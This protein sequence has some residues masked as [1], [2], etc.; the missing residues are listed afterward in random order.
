MS[1]PAKR[2]FFDEAGLYEYAVGALS[3]KMRTVA[4]LKRLLRRRADEELLVDVVI[5]RLKEQKYL[6][7]HKYAAAYSAYRQ[8]NE[9]FGKRRVITDLKTKGVHSEVIEKVVGEAYSGVNEEKLA[10]E[11]LARKRLR[12]PTNERET[13]RV[14]RA[15]LRAGFSSSIIFKI[16]KK[17]QVPDETLG[18]LEAEEEPLQQE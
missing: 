3:R 2:K 1:F 5:A 18:A 14:F 12:K 9:K 6:N 13:A 11:H 10:R 4:E 8:A 17:W 7:D 15:L 16:L